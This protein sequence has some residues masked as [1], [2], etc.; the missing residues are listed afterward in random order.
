[1]LGGPSQEVRC[2]GLQN[3]F[4]LHCFDAEG[5]ADSGAGQFAFEGVQAE[6]EARI[7]LQCVDALFGETQGIR[8]GLV[9]QSE[10]EVR[11]TAPGMLATP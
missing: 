7:V 8:S 4:R 9:D 6:G 2:V 1:M 3:V 5:F 11:G 10:V